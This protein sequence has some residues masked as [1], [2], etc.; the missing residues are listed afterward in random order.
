MKCLLKYCEQCSNGCNDVSVVVWSPAAS[1]PQGKKKILS[2]CVSYIH[3]K[4]LFRLSDHCSLN[5]LP[6]LNRTSNKEGG[7]PLL[8]VWEQFS[9]RGDPGCP[10]PESAPEAQHRGEGVQMQELWQEVPH[11]TG[12]AAPV[13]LLFYHFTA[14]GVVLFNVHLLSNN[15]ASAGH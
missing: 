10:P 9:K 11:Q 7:P 4:V 14:S 2:L 12:S 15:T 5:V 8:A 3:I 13:G 1:E 6:H